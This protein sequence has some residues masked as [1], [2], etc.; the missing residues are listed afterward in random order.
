MNVLAPAGQVG[1][2]PA[3]KGQQPQ[4]TVQVQGRLTSVKQFEN[5]IV[6]ANPNGSLVHIKDI[7]TVQLGSE[8]YTT[9]AALNG[10]TGVMIG[11]YQLPSA[12]A[13]DVAKAVTVKMQQ[14]AAAFPPGL[15]YEVPLNT[16]EFVTA[17]I[18]DVLET[19]LIAFGLVFLVVYV[20]LQSLRATIIPAVVVPVSLIGAVATFTFLHFSINTLTLFGL[21]LAVGLVVD[22][23]IVVGG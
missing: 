20:F 12:N 7:A 9:Y 18:R 13:L 21:V 3:P 16:T 8:F 22:D 14:L 5:V 17:S 2:Q 23:A 19:L 4:L 15:K 11:I 10:Q 1:E 6:R